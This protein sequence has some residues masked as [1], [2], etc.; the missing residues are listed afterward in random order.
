MLLCEETTSLLEMLRPKVKLV[1]EACQSLQ[2][3]TLLPS[4]C[5][6]ILDVGNFLNYGS[7][8][9]NAEGFKISSL[10]K[11]T[12]TKANKSRIT[13]LHHILEEAEANHQELLALPDDI[14]ICQKAAGANLE[15]MQAE[16][17][18]LLKQLNDSAKKVSNSVDE[19]KEQY[20]NLKACQ[21]LNERFTEIEKK[22]SDLAVYLCEDVSQ[23]S[24]EEL[25]GTIRTF[26]EL[27]IKALKENKMRK[28]Q[29]AKAEKRKKQLAEEESKRRKG[30]NGKIIKK[31]VMP[32][33][34][35][36]II[37]HLLADI[38]KGFSLRKTRPRCDSE[39]L[40]SSEMRRDACPPG[41]D[42]RRW[43]PS[44]APCSIPQCFNRKPPT[45]LL[46]LYKPTASVPDTTPPP[47]EA[48]VQ[49][50]LHTN[51]FSLDSTETSVLSP[52]SL[53]DSDLL[54]AVL[55]SA[56]TLVHE[57]SDESGISKS[58][59]NQEGSSVTDTNGKCGELPKGDHKTSHLPEARG[60][61]EDK[62][63]VTV[64]TCGEDEVWSR[65]HSEPKT[66]VV[67]LDEGISGCDVP[68][69]QEPED[70]PSVSEEVSASV[71]PEP[72]KQLKLFKRSKKRSSQGNPFIHYNKDHTLNASF[73]LF[74]KR[75]AIFSVALFNLL[76]ML[77]LLV[78]LYEHFCMT[79][80]I[81]KE[82]Y[83]CKY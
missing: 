12:E 55:D 68:D 29:A 73:S 37:D 36:C 24:L 7:H 20:E 10:L 23:L 61:G 71:A 18:A 13:L 8:T 53:S 78:N 38:R 57:V 35:G 17:G 6:L 33:N 46:R 31:G 77:Y 54:E 3:S 83:K 59:D 65:K 48:E 32:Q 40:S 50:G 34:D 27:F 60:Q 44:S 49:P 26:R 28:E 15:S 30:E 70:V 62:E 41:K 66:S 79:S 5:R 21:S 1:E 56:S 19:V 76:F 16:T 67:A 75:E 58:L 14:E 4:F 47:P 42:K 80:P 74:L 82:Q 81:F 63:Y 22:R 39:S 64:R 9:G 52:S 69:G 25:F 2:M 51:S 43:F 45:C 72:K 11:L